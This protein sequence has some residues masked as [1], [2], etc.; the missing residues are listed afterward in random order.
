MWSLH[1][2]RYWGTMNN[3]NFHR[4]V[5]FQVTYGVKKHSRI[6]MST[7]KHQLGCC[8][9]SSGSLLLKMQ[10]EE[11]DTDHDSRDETDSYDS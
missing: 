1:K 5:S 9:C 8:T 4:F 6:G 10:T 3:N 11:R 7:A 2:L